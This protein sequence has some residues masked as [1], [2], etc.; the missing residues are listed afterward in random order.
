MFVR[1]HGTTRLPTGPI[2]M[3]IQVSSK[4]DRNNTL[5][6]KTYVHLWSYPVQFFFMWEMGYS[7]ESWTLASRWTRCPTRVALR[8]DVLSSSI[9]SFPLRHTTFLFYTRPFFICVLCYRCVTFGLALIC[10]KCLNIHE[11]FI[12]YASIRKCLNIHDIFSSFASF[13]F[14][15]KI[16]TDMKFAL[17]A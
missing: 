16:H 4:S 2:F 14:K 10:P 11:I 5:H 3:K 15:P 7:I 8:S 6:M 13:P 17:N 9:A 12:L 1:P